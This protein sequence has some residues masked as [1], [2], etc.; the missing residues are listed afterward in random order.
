VHHFLTASVLVN[1]ACGVTYILYQNHI[2]VK[3]KR[4]IFVRQL[5]AD[6]TCDH[7]HQWFQQY[8]AVTKYVDRHLLAEPVLILLC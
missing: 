5:A 4:R 2:Q 1:R 7:L 8:G 6:T 3:E